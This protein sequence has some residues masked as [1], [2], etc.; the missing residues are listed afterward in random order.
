MPVG[1]REDQDTR[2]VRPVDLDNDGTVTELPLPDG[3]KHANSSVVVGD[4]DLIYGHA[5]DY[6]PLKWSCSYR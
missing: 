2:G 6:G 5:F 3:V 1:G 4:D